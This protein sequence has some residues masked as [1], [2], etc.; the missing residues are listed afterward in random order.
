M[1]HRESNTEKT[2]RI[3][4]IFP[5][6]TLSSSYFA[7][8]VD[9]RAP[10]TKHRSCARH[11]FILGTH[12]PL[13][14]VHNGRHSLSPEVQCAPDNHWILIPF[15]LTIPRK[16]TATDVGTGEAGIKGGADGP[17]NN[18]LLL[19]YAAVT[20]DVHIPSVFF[21]LS[22]CLKKKRKETAWPN[23]NGRTVSRNY[24]VRLQ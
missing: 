4:A 18:N 13:R 7:I 8:T 20:R 6:S 16:C 5:V 14:P 11:L 21:P 24:Q 23:K 10:P 9:K 15:I 17:R 3:A 12:S 1:E 19:W 22:L 2:P